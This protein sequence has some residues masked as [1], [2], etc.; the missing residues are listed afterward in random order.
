MVRSKANTNSLDETGLTQAF[1]K[2]RGTS[3]GICEGIMSEVVGFAG[4][5][6]QPDDISLA[7]AH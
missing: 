6:A 4:G 7:C 5:S 3:R 2:A 1:L